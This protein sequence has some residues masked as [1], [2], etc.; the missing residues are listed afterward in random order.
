MT[1]FLELIAGWPGKI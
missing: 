1:W